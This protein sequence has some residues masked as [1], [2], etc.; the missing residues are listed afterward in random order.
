MKDSKGPARLKPSRDSLGTAFW[1]AEESQTPSLRPN[2][3]FSKHVINLISYFL[4]LPPWT[5]SKTQICSQRL[6]IFPPREIF[7]GCLKKAP[8]NRKNKEFY[9]LLSQFTLCEAYFPRLFIRDDNISTPQCFWE[10]SVVIHVQ[11]LAYY[12]VHSI[13]SISTHCYYF[14]GEEG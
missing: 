3:L 11:F 13:K 6:E 10:N 4:I 12:L 9:D 14:R 5:L 8:S 7:T 1:P 2:L